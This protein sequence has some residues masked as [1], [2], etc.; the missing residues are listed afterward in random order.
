MAI[1]TVGE[2]VVVSLVWP[3]YC[4]SPAIDLD[5]TRFRSHNCNAQNVDRSW[6]ISL[7]RD[8]NSLVVKEEEVEGVEEKGRKDEKN[9]KKILINRFSTIKYGSLCI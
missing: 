1:R 9:Y 5:E 4:L 3:L 2:S 8:L 7:W 6:L